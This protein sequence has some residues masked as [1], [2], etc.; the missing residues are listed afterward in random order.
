[1]TTQSRAYKPH[2]G[3]IL[4][5]MLGTF[6]NKSNCLVPIKKLGDGYYLF[7]SRKIYAKIL[8]GKLVIRVGGGYMIIE[9][10][11]ST[12]A[13]K[14]L[15]KMESVNNKQAEKPKD[16]GRRKSARLDQSQEGLSYSAQPS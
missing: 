1:M 10:F 15:L 9:E 5:E 3:D 11:I 6:I 8:N 16:L 2:S 14:E 12:F 13:E 4:D 7:G